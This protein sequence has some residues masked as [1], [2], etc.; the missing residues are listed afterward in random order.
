MIG[1]GVCIW[2]GSFAIGINGLVWRQVLLVNF[3]SVAH[4]RYSVAKISC[5]AHS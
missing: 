4:I 5:H 1:V 3:R 2:V